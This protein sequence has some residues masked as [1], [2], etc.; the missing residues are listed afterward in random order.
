MI[1]CHL[2]NL[3]WQIYDAYSSTFGITRLVKLNGKENDRS[4]NI[5]ID[6]HMLS[7]PWQISHA[8]TC[9]YS[10]RQYDRNYPIKE[11]FQS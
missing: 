5:M 10:I 9:T 11:V 7:L 6:C 3:Q 1:D 4:N 8:C 2:I